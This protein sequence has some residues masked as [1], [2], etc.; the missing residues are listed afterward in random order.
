MLHYSML[1]RFTGQNLRAFAKE[2]NIDASDVSI[3][4]G[5]MGLPELRPIRA[6]GWHKGNLIIDNIDYHRF[7]AEAYFQMHSKH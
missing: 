3:H 1:Q 5:A 4:V 7:I 6:Q 2:L